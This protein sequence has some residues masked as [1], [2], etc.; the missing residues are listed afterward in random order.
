MANETTM[1]MGATWRGT[2]VTNA[3]MTEATLDNAINVVDC[4]ALADEETDNRAGTKNPTG[5][6]TFAR[7]KGG[8]A[9]TPGDI[10]AFVVDGVEV[11]KM[12]VS[13][14]SYG[15]T[16]N[17]VRTARISLVSTK[18]DLTT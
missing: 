3:H 17:G 8:T 11:A 7:G 18:G 15:G 12:M 1:G 6:F 10:G 9:P 4:T 2:V 16:V 5:S 14:V 13:S